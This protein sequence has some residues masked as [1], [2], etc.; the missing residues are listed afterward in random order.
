MY[1]IAEHGNELQLRRTAMSY[2][3]IRLQPPTV[4]LSQAMNNFQQ[5]QTG[6]L[7]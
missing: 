6:R 1:S 2:N 3:S 5:Q 7:L 4:E